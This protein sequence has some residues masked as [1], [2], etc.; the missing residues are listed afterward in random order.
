MRKGSKEKRKRTQTATY[1]RQNQQFWGEQT[2]LALRSQKKAA[3]RA[4]ACELGDGTLLLAVGHSTY[5]HLFAHLT[6]GTNNGCPIQLRGKENS[7][8]KALLGASCGVSSLNMPSHL[9]LKITPRMS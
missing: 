7:C 3:E 1:S 4:L 2:V 9:I 8:L 6:S 5:W